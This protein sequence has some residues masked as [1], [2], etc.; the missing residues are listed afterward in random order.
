MTCNT[1]W[2][3]HSAPCIPLCYHKLALNHRVGRPLCKKT[4]AQESGGS[5]KSKHG[6]S[7]GTAVEL[8]DKMRGLFAEQKDAAVS[9]AEDID[10]DIRKLFGYSKTLSVKRDDP[11]H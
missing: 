2:M 1:Q 5:Y 4:N 11:K 7:A 10:R 6:H 8:A 9:R 3:K